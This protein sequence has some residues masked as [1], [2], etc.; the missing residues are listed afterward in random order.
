MGVAQKAILEALQLLHYQRN[1]PFRFPSG[2]MET[3]KLIVFNIV[4]KGLANG[5][6]TLVHGGLGESVLPSYGFY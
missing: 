2:D 6:C 4:K 5:R 1:H 3:S